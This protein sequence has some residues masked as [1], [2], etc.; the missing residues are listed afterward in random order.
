MNQNSKATGGAGIGG[1]IGTIIVW[2]GPQAGWF[3]MSSPEEGAMIATALGVIVAF[4]VRWLPEP[5]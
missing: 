3:T 2:Y 5:K 4:A 1:A